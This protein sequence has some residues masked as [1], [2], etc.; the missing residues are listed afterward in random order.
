MITSPG[1]SG[2]PGPIIV[3]IS[4]DIEAIT[5]VHPST[6]TGRA[7]GS[8]GDRMQLVRPQFLLRAP[9]VD[10]GTAYEWVRRK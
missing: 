5:D 7:P 4:A 6:F 1:A 3:G 8:V 9:L 2:I 10:A